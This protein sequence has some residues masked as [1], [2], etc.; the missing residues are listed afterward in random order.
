[1]YVQSRFQIYNIMG[2]LLNK[3][4]DINNLYEAMVK[5]SRNSN[6]KSSNQRFKMNFLINLNKLHKDLISETY[7]QKNFYRFTIH[8]RGK[9]RSVR[10]I[11]LRDRIVQRS[12]CDNA[13]YDI[14][15]PK[16]IYDNGASIKNKGISF[17]R[18]R[19]DC[20][21]Q[22]YIRKHGTS[23]YILLIDFSKFFD[24]ISHERLYESANTIIPDRQL[25]NLVCKLIDS[26]KIDASELTDEEYE[27]LRY[28][29]FDSNKY[30][31]PKNGG[32]RY[33]YKSLG[34]GSQLSQIFGVYYPTIIDLYCK[35][36]K[37]F[38]Y[39]GRY[40]DDIYVIHH[41]KRALE[42]LLSDLIILCESYGGL[43]I[44][45][46]KT[47]ITPLSHG[48]TFMQVKYSIDKSSGHIL[49][50]LK[51]DRFHKEKR[52]IKAYSKFIESGRMEFDDAV[53]AYKSWRCNLRGF[54][55]RKS[56]YQVDKL[57][58]C[59]VINKY[60]YERD[61]SGDMQPYC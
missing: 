52:K 5:C 51:P 7:E 16:L 60:G 53:N 58:N 46:N 48:F 24:N 35:V 31:L 59:E 38:K 43:F 18:K 23:G 22:K 56:V 11:H 21:L 4:A 13:L 41:D 28:S 36:R 57:F 55:C 45:K 20:H 37:G 27:R 6:W 25:L 32:K 8:E 2:E 26:F 49:K 39:Y 3:V 14:I 40:M 30:T 42:V 15:T 19:L 50:R 9:V 34:I 12:M 44:N 1:M 61:L 33:I 29:V 17:T 47:S 54:D 10:S